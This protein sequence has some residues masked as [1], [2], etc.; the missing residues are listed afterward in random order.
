MGSAAGATTRDMNP[1]DM[2]IATATLAFGKRKHRLAIDIAFDAIG[3]IAAVEAARAQH[4]LPGLPAQFDVGAFADQLITYIA[5]SRDHAPAHDR[6][7]AC[8][9]F[10]PGSGN[11]LTIASTRQITVNAVPYHL[12]NLEHRPRRKCPGAAASHLIVVRGPPDR[13][14]ADAVMKGIVPFGRPIIG[15]LHDLFV[16]LDYHSVLRNAS[17]CSLRLLEAIRYCSAKTSETAAREKRLLRNAKGGQVE[18][19]EELR[20]FARLAQ[21]GTIS[22]AARELDLSVAS[23]SK[24]LSRLEARLGVRLF[25]RSTQGLTLTDEGSAALNRAHRLI[26]DSDALVAMFDE[27]GEHDSGTLRVAAPTRFGERYVSAA[28]AEFVRRYPQVRVDFHLTDRQQDL[29]AEGLD[30]AIRI[31]PLTDS[32]NVA[33]PLFGNRRVVVAAPAYLERRGVPSTPG[34]LAHHDCLV[35]EDNDVW[36]FRDGDAAQ[37]V[38]I[39]ARVRCRRGDAI[40]ALCVAGAGI[41]LKS[42]WDVVDDFRSGY[43]VRILEDYPVLGPADI[44]VLLPDRRYVPPR[45]RRFIET[46]REHI[47]EPPPWAST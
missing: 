43:L 32:R 47:G 13:P 36:H 8:L 46:L 34:E 35:L 22:R 15:L 19:T 5:Q 40:S 14:M 45:V 9:R 41:A 29:V 17:V 23:V 25:H 6:L 28:V 33:K 7:E 16:R 2:L 4:R 1:R 27:R 30:L 10:V 18:L 31:G 24:C 21:A 39:A 26:D 12:G 44:S 11:E 3:D 37:A 38:R 20:V 42:V